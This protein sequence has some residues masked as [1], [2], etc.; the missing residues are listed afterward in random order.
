MSLSIGMT[1]LY[2]IFPVGLLLFVWVKYW[3]EERGDKS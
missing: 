2:I 3:L 1:L